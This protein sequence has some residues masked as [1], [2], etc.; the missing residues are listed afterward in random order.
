MKK[1]EPS[2][3]ASGNATV[4]GNGLV[5]SHILYILIEFLLCQVL[6][7]GKWTE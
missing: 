7:L 5:D 6:G 2:F 1:L 4:V 3:I